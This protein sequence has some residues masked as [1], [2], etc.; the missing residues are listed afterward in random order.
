MWIRTICF[1]MLALLLTTAYHSSVSADSADS[2]FNQNQ[3]SASML[4]KYAASMR[5]AAIKQDPANRQTYERKYVLAYDV[6][7]KAN[8]YA[9][10]NKVF[11]WLAVIAAL[12]VLI[13]PSLGVVFKHKLDR[14]EWLKSAV[15][16]TTVTGIAALTFAFYSQYKD[17]QVYAETLMRHVI[18]SE[19]PVSSLSLKVVEELAKIDRGFSFNSVINDDRTQTALPSPAQSP[20][21]QQDAVTP[22]SNG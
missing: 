15:V 11:F 7:I 18:F 6:Y 10:I 14:M 21:S 12:G 8:S 20:M 22:E 13:W 19:Q 9:I 16:Q 17:K 2:M 5:D 1:T 3:T 4:I